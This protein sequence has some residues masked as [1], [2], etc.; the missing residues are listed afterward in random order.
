M[1]IKHCNC[2]DFLS[3]EIEC[4]CGESVFWKDLKANKTETALFSVKPDVGSRTRVKLLLFK[5]LQTHRE[6]KS[7]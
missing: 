1:G 6:T 3:M 4:S 2:F 5:H 7:A